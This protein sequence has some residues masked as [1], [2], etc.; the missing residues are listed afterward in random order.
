[1]PPYPG[2]TP[3]QQPT[4]SMSFGWNWRRIQT[5][6]I[7]KPL[8][9]KTDQIRP[10]K[11]YRWPRQTFQHIT[12]AFDLTW[13]DIMVI[14]NQTLSDPEHA[15]VLKEARRYAMLGFPCGS[16]GK[17]FTCNARVLGSIP[18]LGR[19]PGKESGNPLQYSCLGN[20]TDRRSLVGYSPWGHK[21]VKHN[22]AT[23]QQSMLRGFTC[24]AIN[25]Q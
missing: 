19:S 13:K 18:R 5:K 20:P 24:H 16:A 4:F 10:K 22:L 15:R 11:L 9:T 25:I 23:K 1:M 17:E 21:R 8:R 12:L 3:P 6:E 2:A 14:F 7:H